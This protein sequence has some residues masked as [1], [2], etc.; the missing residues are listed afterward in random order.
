MPNERVKFN[1]TLGS[2]IGNVSEVTITNSSTREI[3]TKKLFLFN[4]KNDNSTSED[5][6]IRISP[7]KTVT[8]NPKALQFNPEADIHFVRVEFVDAPS[9]KASLFLH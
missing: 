6:S 7:K 9:E 1:P 3:E 4:D 8:L 2:T 5:S